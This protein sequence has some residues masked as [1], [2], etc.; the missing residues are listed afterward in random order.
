MALLGAV[1]VSGVALVAAPGAAQTPPLTCTFLASP[2]V[3]PPDGGVVSVSGTAPASSVVRVF[4][5]GELVATTFSDPVTGSFSVQVVVTTSV[6]I[7]VAVD[8][9][10][11]TPCTG[12]GVAP[13]E[14]TRGQA[15]GRLPRTGSSGTGRLVRVG[16]SA[17]ALGMVLVVGARR[18]AGA[19]GGT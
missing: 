7:T 4:A 9:Y 3:L 15:T 13:G 14:V 2:A 6:E 10:P 16:V 1:G 18:R 5:D 8:D 11:N 19:R 12:V 17:L